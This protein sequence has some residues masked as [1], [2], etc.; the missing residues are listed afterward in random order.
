VYVYTKVPYKAKVG[1]YY[2]C[3]NKRFN[4]SSHKL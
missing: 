4:E 1:V 2:R 3:I